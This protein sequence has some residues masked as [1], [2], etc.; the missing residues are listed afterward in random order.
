MAV[1]CEECQLPRTECAENCAG[2][3][4]REYF[5]AMSDWEASEYWVS[6]PPH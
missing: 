4:E 5:K 1:Y 2:R 3:R 6:E